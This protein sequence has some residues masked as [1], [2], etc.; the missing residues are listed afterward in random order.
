MDSHIDKYKVSFEEESVKYLDIAEK[1]KNLIEEGEIQDGNK[2]P[3]IKELSSYLGV[4]KVTVINAYGKLERE[5]Y[6]LKVQGSGVYA[7][8]REVI[9]NFK[10]DYTETFRRMVAGENENWIDFTGETTNANFFSV[11]NLRLVLNDVLSRDGAGALVYND[12]LGYKNLRETINN[13]FWDGANDLEDMLVISGAQQGIDIVSKAILNVQDTVLVEKPTYGGALTVFKWR[14]ANII[15]VPIKQ[16]GI[17]IISLEKILKK[18]KV[19]LLYTMSYFQN[20]TGISCSLE[21]KQKVLELAKKYDFYILEDDYLSE[22]IYDNNIYHCPYK[23]LDS[24]RVIYIKSFSKIFLPGVRIGYLIAPKE[25]REILQNS[26]VN[27]DIATSS[28]MQRALELYISKGYW[29]D[30]IRCLNS[31]Y[32]KRYNYIVDLIKEKLGNMVE[33]NEPKGGLNLF[34]NI[35][36]NI[37][38]TSMDL[39][40]KL[41]DKKVIITPGIMFYKNPKDGEKSFRIGFSQ[42][43]YK[44]IDYGIDSIFTVLT[45]SLNKKH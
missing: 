15:E 8:K 32:A 1:V 12:A 44:N 40:Y 28:L 29:I 41:R 26:K 17:D 14:R 6:V 34:L 7:K 5:G 11:D 43:D 37:N 38:M 36:K 19:K 9:K 2:L 35:N 45:D 27:T 20:P 31:E 4:N 39:F 18:Q 33:F 10:K 3:T 42:I 23:K 25:F 13:K 24:D 21:K 22:L 16:D 30:H